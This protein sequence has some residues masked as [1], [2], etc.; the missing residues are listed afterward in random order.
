M[1][2]TRNT[3][4]LYVDVGCPQGR[5]PTGRWLVIFE[6]RSQ[7]S[8]TD[9]LAQAQRQLKE[10]MQPCLIYLRVISLVAHLAEASARVVS[11]WYS[12]A[13]APAKAMVSHGPSG[14]R[15]ARL[16]LDGGTTGK[17]P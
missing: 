12:S 4:G 2:C 15:N 11:V 14:E 9:R 13:P 3:Q 10:M 8:I 6:S 17:R 5:E 7:S 1:F 16:L